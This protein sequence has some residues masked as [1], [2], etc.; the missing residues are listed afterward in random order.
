MRSERD[1]SLHPC[2]GKYK[3]E[4]TVRLSMHNNGC[5]SVAVHGA[6][7]MHRCVC[8][9]GRSLHAY[10]RSSKLK[11]NRASNKLCVV[12]AVCCDGCV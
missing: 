5:A 2:P 10:R 4:P 8:E 11:P 1:L 12:M 3:S 9:R 6:L 7:V